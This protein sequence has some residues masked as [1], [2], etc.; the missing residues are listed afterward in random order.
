MLLDVKDLQNLR[1]VIDRIDI[2]KM[3]K[4]VCLMERMAATGMAREEENWNEL[5]YGLLNFVWDLPDHAK[6][7][8]A[9]RS[10]EMP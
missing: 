3:E 2:E 5:L 1:D 7:A 6:E 10:K 4:V 9:C 8:M